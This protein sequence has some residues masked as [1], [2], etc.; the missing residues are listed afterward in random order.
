MATQTGTVIKSLVSAVDFLDQRQ[1]DPCVYDQARDRS[2]T[3]IFKRV[4]RRKS[5][6]MSTYH[7][8][9]NEDVYEN[10]T[11]S[12][13]A[14]PN[15][16]A[17]ITFTVNTGIKFPRVGDTWE[18]NNPNNIGKQGVVV[19][20]TRASATATITVR[21]V[22]G[23][24]SH[25]YANVGDRC[26]FGSNVQ[27]EQ[28]SAPT[29]RVYNVVKYYNQTQIFREVDEISDVQKVSKVEFTVGGQ[30]YFLP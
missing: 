10:C 18:S 4:N 15:G 28:S 23:N 21:A 30:S 2:F 9:T 25:L 7:N 22:G 27:S 19:A 8:W 17:Q 6:S 1:I 5:T 12:V 13:A 26:V 11:V 24:D 20:V 3:D 14:S 16:F 29:N